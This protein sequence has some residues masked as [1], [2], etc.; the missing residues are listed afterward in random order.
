MGPIAVGPDAGPVLFGPCTVGASGKV[1]IK[2]KGPTEAGVVP[3]V[4]R[5]PVTFIPEIIPQL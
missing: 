3:G 2:G 4:F 1:V 5:S